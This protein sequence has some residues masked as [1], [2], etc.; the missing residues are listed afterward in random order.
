MTKTSH[1][2]TKDEM[3]S[4]AEYWAGRSMEECIS[5]TCFMVEQYISW[6]NLPTRMDKTVF[7]KIDQHKA[8][9]EEQKIWDS[10]TAE[11]KKMFG[12]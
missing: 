9:A 2:Y 3:P 5:A 6:N 7:Q 1:K 11:E 10:F 4:D 12:R 8:W